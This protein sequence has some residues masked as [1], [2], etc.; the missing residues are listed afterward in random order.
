MKNLRSRAVDL[1]QLLRTMLSDFV[2][3][4]RQ[5]N[6]DFGLETTGDAPSSSTAIRCCS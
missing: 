5:K 2:P 4:A 6:I 1:E 3:R